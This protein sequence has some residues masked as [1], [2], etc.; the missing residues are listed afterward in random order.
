MNV[1]ICD[2]CDQRIVI[3]TGYHVEHERGPSILNPG[4]W[5]YCSWTCMAADAM[6]RSAG[7]TR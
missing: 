4:E 1:D 3:W 6:A 5:D 7:G 2:H